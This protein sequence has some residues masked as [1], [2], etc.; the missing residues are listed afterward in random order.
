MVKYLIDPTKTA[1]WV[2]VL[3]KSI[4]L[5]R[6]SLVR[7]GIHEGNEL[8]HE[9]NVTSFRWVTYLLFPTPKWDQQLQ[10]ETSDTASFI[11]ETP[12]LH[13]GPLEFSRLN[14]E[15]HGVL[16]GAPQHLKLRECSPAIH[17]SLMMSSSAWTEREDT[18]SG[19]TPISNMS[20]NVLY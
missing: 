5:V 1:L 18:P 11:P 12:Y 13:S 20:W 3:E 17:V 2:D 7:F 8:S 19:K 6:H 9:P 16:A 15:L 10:T 4:G 14:E